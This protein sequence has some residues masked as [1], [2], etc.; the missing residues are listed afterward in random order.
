PRTQ[1]FSLQTEFAVGARAS[2]TVGYQGVNGTHLTRTRDINLFP[3]VATAAVICPTSA[4]CTADQGQAITFFRHPGT[5]GPVRPNPAFGRISIFDSG[6]NSI[7]HAGFISFNRRYS[8]NFQVSTSYTWAKVIDSA[9]D[10]TS[11]VPGNGG[12]DSKVALDTL[13]P[14]L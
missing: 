7:Y 10:A 4:A 13:A 12:D 1:Q 3:S 9:P 8:N 6:A 2:V 11:V 5:A 14:N